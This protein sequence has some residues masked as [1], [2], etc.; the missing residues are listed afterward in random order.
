M[1]EWLAEQ[2]RRGLTPATRET[3]RIHVRRFLRWCAKREVETPDW[4]SPGLLREWLE[5]LEVYRTRGSQ[6]LAESS[7]E[8]ILRAVNAFLGYL[9]VRHV[10]E[11][12]PLEGYRIMHRKGRDLPSVL[13][14]SEVSALLLE[15]DTNDVLGLR[16]RAILELLYSS[17][18]RRAELAYLRLRD[19]RINAGLLTVRRAK[20]G[21]QRVAPVGK[22]A[23]HWLKRYLTDARPALVVPED[24]SDHVF[25]T[26]YGS[27]FSVAYLG[28]LVRK[29][30]DRIGVKSKGACHLMR[31]ACATHM[32]DHGSDLRTIQT[33][34]GHSRLD[35]TEIYTHV[36]MERMREVH[37]ASHPRG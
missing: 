31:H 24:P 18:L 16:D 13:D 1:D 10:I 20:G 6:P 2:R 30:L 5:W 26:S 14:E 33:M 27:R 12:N 29:H 21:K 7:R 36:S 19:L 22:V 11:G 4:L 15:P 35:T 32:L 37:H 9:V 28:V 25:L 34:L 23:T 17:G 8:G 3:R